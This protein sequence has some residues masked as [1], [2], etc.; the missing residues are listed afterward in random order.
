MWSLA[1]NSIS[2]LLLLPVPAP[3]GAIFIV[4]LATKLGAAAGGRKGELLA[5]GWAVVCAEPQKGQNSAVASSI[6]C[7]QALLLQVRFGMRTPKIESMFSGIINSFSIVAFVGGK[8][9][10]KTETGWH[11]GKSEKETSLTANHTLC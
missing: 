4:L 1:R 9:R 7:L 2:L 5:A 8:E 11:P 6:V 3:G 10:R